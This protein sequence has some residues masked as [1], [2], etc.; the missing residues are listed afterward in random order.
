M[1]RLPWWGNIL[2]ELFS[3]SLWMFAMWAIAEWKGDVLS[4]WAYYL[5]AGLGIHSWNKVHYNRQQDMEP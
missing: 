2:G 3:V 1:R 4:I 5:A